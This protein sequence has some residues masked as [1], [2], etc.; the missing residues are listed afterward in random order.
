MPDWFFC[1]SG[2][3][4]SWVRRSGERV[5]MIWRG[6]IDRDMAWDEPC[7]ITYNPWVCIPEDV[8]LQPLSQDQPANLPEGWKAYRLVI[9]D[10]GDLAFNDSGMSFHRA[11]LYSGHY[12]MIQRGF[13]WGDDCGADQW[14]VTDS[15][16]FPV[17]QTRPADWILFSPINTGLSWQ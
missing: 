14:E 16:P 6:D 12:G 11:S 2:S 7:E 4:K 1:F 5:A 17:H 15:H 8:V 13:L 9:D 10:G 3:S